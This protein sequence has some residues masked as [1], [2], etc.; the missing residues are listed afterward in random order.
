MTEPLDEEKVEEGKWNQSDLV[1]TAWS[2][3]VWSKHSGQYLKSVYILVLS[4]WPLIPLISEPQCM[5]YAFM[6]FKVINCYI[7][8]TANF[9]M[10]PLSKW[11]KLPFSNHVIGR[12]TFKRIN[13]LVE[14]SYIK[15]ET[16]VIKICFS[17]KQI[18]FVKDVNGRHK[19][20]FQIIP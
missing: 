6:Y 13:Y 3:L 1:S 7:M 8:I 12:G 10:L 17:I 16:T 4:I 11:D 18:M 19:T 14:I 15:F 2:E 9:M 20:N 5:N